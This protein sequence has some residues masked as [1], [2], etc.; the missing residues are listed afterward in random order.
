VVAALDVSGD[1][2]LRADAHDRERHELRDLGCSRDRAA[3]AASCRK[4]RTLGS[5]RHPNA[6][7]AESLSSCRSSPRPVHDR[8]SDTLP[9]SDGCGRLEL[10]WQ[11]VALDEGQASVGAQPAPVRRLHS[12]N[13]A[14]TLRLLM[15][16]DTRV[17]VPRGRSRAAASRV[18]G[19]DERRVDD[20]SKGVTSSTNTSLDHS[21]HWAR[22]R[23]SQAARELQARPP[24]PGDRAPR[25]R[26]LRRA[27]GSLLPGRV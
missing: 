13:T 11:A 6:G 20:T 3:A 4:W 5:R 18:K 10:R 17:L 22:R 8:R 16:L 23:R 2:G 14:V 15:Q 9:M 24:R 12:W 25:V 19:A 1:G 27:P 26:R 21:N 7:V